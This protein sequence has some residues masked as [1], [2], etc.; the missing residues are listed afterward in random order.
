MSTTRDPLRDLMQLRE[1]VNQLFNETLSTESHLE[2]E[3]PSGSWS[4]AVDIQETPERFVL[5]ADLPGLSVEQIELRIEND[6]LS[7]KGDRPFSAAA[8]REDFHRIERSHGRFS[9]S[10]ALPRTL[11]HSEVRAELKNG[12]LEVVLPKKAETQARQ[13]RV[14]VR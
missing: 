7:I 10:F 3:V 6:R 12:V 13:I 2:H 4:P 5:R 1:R 9:R 8:R 11:N 14:D